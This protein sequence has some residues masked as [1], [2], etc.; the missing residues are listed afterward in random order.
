MDLKIKSF[1]HSYLHIETVVVDEELVQ[2][3]VSVRVLEDPPHTQ[4]G[5]E[6][7]TSAKVQQLRYVCREKRGLEGWRRGRRGRKR[8]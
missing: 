2:Q 7:G 5:F 3:V 8:V 1:I 4:Q 6:H